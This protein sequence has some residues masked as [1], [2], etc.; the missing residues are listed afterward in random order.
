VSDAGETDEFPREASFA[1]DP[2]THDQP[3][4][5]KLSQALRRAVAASMDIAADPQRVAELAAQAEALASALEGVAHGNP[6]PLFGA[7]RQ[8]EQSMS[9]FLP[10]SPLMGHLN[11]LA[12]PLV[13]RSED[14]RAVCEV[15]LTAPYQGA[16]GIVHGGVVAAI[17]DEIL[18]MANLIAGVP[19]PTGRL[20]VRYRKPT[21][22]FQTLRFEAWVERV[23]DR[24]VITRGACFVGEQ[25]VSDAEGLF[26]QFDGGATAVFARD[27]LGG[28]GDDP[29]EGDEA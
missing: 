16:K 9:G 11:P 17:Y 6:L 23:D 29:A 26:V 4:W 28:G 2:K 18:A 13:V 7:S 20:E 21:P 10:F 1:H 15:E 3:E 19:G 22:L 14:G 27:V 12:P 25:R 8:P 24:K 5:S